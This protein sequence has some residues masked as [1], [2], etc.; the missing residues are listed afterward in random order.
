MKTC[1]PIFTPPNQTFYDLVFEPSII[2]IRRG[3]L[4][5][6]LEQNINSNHIIQANATQPIVD[7]MAFNPEVFIN[8]YAFFE[9]TKNI[10]SIKDFSFMST[11][12]KSLHAVVVSTC[13]RMFQIL[14]VSLQHRITI[15]RLGKTQKFILTAATSILPIYAMTFLGFNSIE[16]GIMSLLVSVSPYILSNNW[17]NRIREIDLI[18]NTKEFVFKNSLL[19]NCLSYI[20]TIISNLVV[21]FG[22]SVF[23]SALY[24]FSNHAIFLSFLEEEVAG[25][26]NIEICRLSFGSSLPYGHSVSTPALWLTQLL[27]INMAWGFGRLVIDMG[28]GVLNK[29]NIIP[30]ARDLFYNQT[31]RKSS[32]SLKNASIGES[33]EA[34]SDVQQ[35]KKRAAAPVSYSEY[36]PSNPK[37]RKARCKKI[38]P[39]QKV[40][41]GAIPNATTAVYKDLPTIQVPDYPMQP[42]VPF[43]PAPQS[44]PTYGVVANTKCRQFDLFSRILQNAANSVA[45]AEGSI[46]CLNTATQVYAIRRS[47]IDARLLGQKAIGQS[48]VVNILKRLYGYERAWLV[49]EMDV[50]SVVPFAK[51][52]NHT[53]LNEAV[54]SFGRAI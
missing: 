17:S 41:D 44:A 30:D 36:T 38:K 54:A 40:D 12:D 39:E 3:K 31:F 47:T 2:A 20:R 6:Y 45:N 51:E 4:L 11:Y 25:H 34:R 16:L 29:V 22:I 48:A 42:L 13:F 8:P 35:T 23:Y 26:Y 24:A 28:I 50:H 43:Y 27:L 49:E 1:T 14:S 15:S 18:S 19:N 7:I 37:I 46:E 9:H 10:N 21:E 5:G 33:L 53:R 32:V 52:T